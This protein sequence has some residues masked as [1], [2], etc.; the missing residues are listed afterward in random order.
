M[1]DHCTTLLFLQRVAFG[2]ELV[3]KKQV[4]GEEKGG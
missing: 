1:W 2:D 4:K 3:C